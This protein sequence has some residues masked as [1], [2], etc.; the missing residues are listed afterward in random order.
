MRLAAG[1]GRVNSDSDTQFL[2]R[3]PSFYGLKMSFAAGCGRVNSYCT[4]YY[5]TPSPYPLHEA[6][7]NIAHSTSS[8][9][10]TRPQPLENLSAAAAVDGTISPRQLLPEER[11]A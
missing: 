4:L 8:P 6:P 5:H 10:R 3:R 9:G 2:N 11:T 1:R 7:T